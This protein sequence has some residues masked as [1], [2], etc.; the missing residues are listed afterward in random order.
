FNTIITSL[1]AL[2]EGFSS[3]NYVRK[4]LRAL[5]PKRRVKVTTIEESKNLSSLALEELIDN[6][7]VHEVVM[8][9]VSKFYKGKKKIVKSIALKAKKESSN[10][11]T[12]HPEAKRSH[13]DKELRRKERVTE[14]IL[15]S[16]IQIISL[17]IVQNHIATR[18]KRPSLEVLGAIEK[19][20]PKT[21]PTMKLVSWLNRRM[22]LIAA[23]PKKGKSQTLSFTSPQS[24]CLEA[25]GALSKK[26]KSPKSKNPPTETKVTPPKPMEGSEQS[27]SVSSGT[28][29]KPTSSTA[30]YLEASDIDSLSDDMLK[31]IM[32]LSCTLNESWSSN[33][34]KCHTDQLVEVSLSY[35]KKSNTTIID[36]YKGIEVI[37][38]LLKDIKNSIKD[39]LV[40][41]KKIK[42]ASKTLA[43]ISTLT[44][45]ILS[46]VR[47]FDFFTLLSTIKNIQDYAF[48]QEEALDAWMKS[49]TNMA[50]NIGSRISGLERAQTHIQSSIVTSTF[51]I[52]DTPANIKGENATYATTKE[53]LSHTEGETDANIQEN[54]KEPKQS[55]DADIRKGKGIATNDKEEDQRKLDKEEKIKKAKEEARLNTI[56][57]T[58]VIKVV[59]EEAKK[60]GIHLKEEI[61]SKAD[62]LFKKIQDAKHEVLKRQYTEKVRKSLEL[63]KHKYDSY[64]W[65]ISIRLRPEPTTNI[66][67]HPKTKPVLI[68]VYRGTDGRIFDV[69]KPFLFQAFSISES[70]ELREIIPKKK[71][72]VVKDL[73]NSLSRRYKRFR[74]IFEKLGIQSALLA[75][76]QALSQTSGRKQ[77]HM[78]LEPKKIIPGLECNRTLLKN[79]PFVNNMVIKEPE[80][81]IFF[82]DKFGDQTFQRW[83]DIDKVGMEAF[84]SY[85][86]A[87]SMVK[88]LENARF[89]MKLRKLIAEHPDQ[90]KL[91]SKKVKL[92]ALRYKID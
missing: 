76:E 79:I 18:I 90:E 68:T 28:G 31:N 91:K 49:S 83:S 5:Y 37:T 87:E 39:D 25:S 16:M 81:G 70:D 30:P 71:N 34:G 69:H 32:T 33:L 85:L 15:D 8:E 53:L 44:T 11:E 27:H 14:N 3:K 88:S 74:Q 50:W 12:R 92:E 55:T 63:R 46:S 13:S 73:M 89:I 42:E 24:Q 19:M 38:Q 78:E 60:I 84:V 9:K 26:N 51:S 75:P 29:D 52:T 72:T 1:K 7:K 56:S 77:K 86:V 45:V 4:F 62:E 35:L 64:M 20:T 10:D 2:D 57:K 6:L 41:N 40:I 47:S 80:Y 82:T 48:K 17:A 54:L 65:P 66:N 22:R 36:L 58:E 23:K 61:S 21:K 59:R 67:I 43:K